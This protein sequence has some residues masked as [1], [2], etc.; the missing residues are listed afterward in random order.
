M[1]SGPTDT[2]AKDADKPEDQPAATAMT[3]TGKNQPAD[4]PADTPQDQPAE[5][6]AAPVQPAVQ[7]RK[8]SR[9]V[10][11]DVSG[12]AVATGAAAASA[13]SD[14]VDEP[15]VVFTVLAVIVACQNRDFETLSRLGALARKMVAALKVPAKGWRK[16]LPVWMD[17]DKVDM[18]SV[19]VISICHQYMSSVYVISICHQYMSS[20]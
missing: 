9:T 2:R 12:V 13:T 5:Q 3:D 20:K 4:P 11:S 16:H 8:R 6:P 18:S 14:V 10:S 7:P 19:Y 17:K 15:V 1:S